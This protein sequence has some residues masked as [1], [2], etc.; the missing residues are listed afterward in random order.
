[1]L[2]LALIDRRLRGNS[3]VAPGLH[4]HEHHGRSVGVERNEV[5][6]VIVDVQVALENPEA[7]GAKVRSRQPLASRAS[8]FMAAEQSVEQAH[9]YRP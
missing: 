7:A 5:S 4:L 3:V 8:R 9:R 6:L 1:M 2:P